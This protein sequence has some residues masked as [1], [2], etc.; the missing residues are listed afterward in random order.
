MSI[1]TV[2]P[3]VIFIIIA[4]VSVSLIKKTVTSKPKYVSGRRTKCILGGYAFILLLAMVLYYIMPS[5]SYT[6]VDLSRVEEHTERENRFKEVTEGNI[7]QVLQDY[8]HKQWE[9]TYDNPQ[10]KLDFPNGFDG[11]TIFIERKHTSDDKMKVII[12]K[13]RTIAD[14]IDLS[15][16]IPFPKVEQDG[17]LLR[18]LEPEHIEIKLAKFSK[19]F[20]ITQFTSED[21]R[22]DEMGFFI[23]ERMVYLQIP[24]NVEISNEEIFPIRYVKE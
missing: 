4:I 5:D 8:K 9:F 15:D 21:E 11:M 7:D 22:Y 24:K 10:L 16:K 17:K 2:L 6:Y 1:L 14:G 23:S 3:V 20:T 18:I 19:E 12:L 13:T